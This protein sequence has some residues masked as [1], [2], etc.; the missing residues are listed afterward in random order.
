MANRRNLSCLIL[1]AALLGGCGE[2]P[3]QAMPPASVTVVTLKSEPVT[4]T[5][6]L[7]GRVIPSLVAEIRP[8][9]NGIVQKRLFDEGGAVK[10]GQVLYQLDDAT[11]RADA[12]RARAAVAR[13]EAGLEAARFKAKRAAELVKIRAI[14]EQDNE[15]AIATL[16]KAEA[17][18]GVA[19]AELEMASIL[20]GY[21]QITS[22][23]SGRIGKSVVTQGALVT[24]NQDEPLV[25]VQQM[26][27]MYVD[28]TQ[29]SA[30]WLQLQ[31]HIAGNRLNDTENVPVTLLLEDGSTYPQQGELAFSEVSVEPSTGSYGLR[32]VV[33]NPDS[34]LLP[35]MYV[36][37]LIATGARPDGVLAPQQGITRDPKG[38]ATAMVV[39]KDSQVEVRTVAVSQAVGDKW[40]VESGL[41]AGDKVIVQGLQKIQPGMTVLVSEAESESTAPELA[42][43]ATH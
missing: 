36:R 27:P 30:E 9:V 20:L 21:S 11:Y 8:Q 23:I 5:R 15:D 1:S 22:P 38:N 14:S 39:N 42:A 2:S 6:E 19:R 28:L 7:T 4:L 34:L 33:K 26:D 3:P 35:G 24:A 13:A 32:V 37:A 40:L 17:D 31:K 29:S 10:A 41:A 43:E 16:R 12:G 18:V 25:T